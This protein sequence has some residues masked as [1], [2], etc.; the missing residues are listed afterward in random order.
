MIDSRVRHATVR[1][2]GTVFRFDTLSTTWWNEIAADDST[3]GRPWKLLRSEG[4]ER[5]AGNW[6]I[7]GLAIAE[8]ERDASRA[9]RVLASV[10]L[11]AGYLRSYEIELVPTGGGWTIRKFEVVHY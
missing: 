7:A 5:H 9:R 10:S 11:A 4:A 3:G 2:S 1:E 8:D 6:L